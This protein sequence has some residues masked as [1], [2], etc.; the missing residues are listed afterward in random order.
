MYCPD[1]DTMFRSVVCYRTTTRYKRPTTFTENKHME[2]KSYGLQHVI[3]SCVEYGVT[4]RHYVTM[5]L[6]GTTSTRQKPMA[7]SGRGLICFETQRR[8][9]FS[10]PNE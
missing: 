1:P 10:Y 8:L 6:P 9:T 2:E 5:G 3:S 4:L 7:H